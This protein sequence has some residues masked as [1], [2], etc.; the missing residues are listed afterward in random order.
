MAVGLVEDAP[1][2]LL[3]GGDLHPERVLLGHG[4]AAHNEAAVGA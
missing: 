4:G 1:H 2:E 3:V